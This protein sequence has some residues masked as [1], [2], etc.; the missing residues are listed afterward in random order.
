MEEDY[1]YDAILAVS[2]DPF[3][4]DSVTQPKGQRIWSS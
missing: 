4:S 2:E 1:N 3:S